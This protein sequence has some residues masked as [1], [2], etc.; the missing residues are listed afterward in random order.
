MNQKTR[1]LIV[2]TI[3]IMFVGVTIACS[4]TDTNT[5]STATTDDSTEI[6][7][8]EKKT[9][10]KNLDGFTFSYVQELDDNSATYSYRPVSDG[11]ASVTVLVGNNKSLIHDDSTIYT[12]EKGVKTIEGIDI[13]MAYKEE[14]KDD[15][16]ILSQSYESLAFDFKHNGKYYSGEASNLEGKPYKD[17]LM[18]V[19]TRFITAIK[20]IQSTTVPKLINGV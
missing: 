7:K 19:L 17:E 10:M 11:N 2:T 9:D 18:N 4:S 6:K 15:G 3:A 16:V 8:E 12:L 13:S 20:S 1:W 14:F 5:S